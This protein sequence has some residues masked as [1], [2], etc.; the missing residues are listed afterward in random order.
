MT[1][2]TK[3]NKNKRGE[4]SFLTEHA[5]GIIVSVLC[6]IV[7]IIIAVVVYNMFSEKSDL[8]KAQSNFKIVKGE[9]ELVRDSP[10][11]NSG[12]IIVYFPLK[13]VIRS[14]NQGFPKSECYGTKSCLC[15]CQ[16]K[17]CEGVQKICEGF[18]YEIE[19]NSSYTN[20]NWYNYGPIRF[21]TDTYPNAIG[22]I[23]SAEGLRIYN[24][25]DKIIITQIRV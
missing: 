19:I 14:Y 1:N 11:V 12:Q 21:N 22:F 18:P 10:G 16:D 24:Q 4:I 23:K 17:T 13:W 25:D 7:L 2:K 8:E 15:T 5:L 20:S 3:K 6:L 9:I